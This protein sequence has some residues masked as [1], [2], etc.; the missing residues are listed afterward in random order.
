[1]T[2][3]DELTVAGFADEWVRFD[4]TQL[5]PEE[6]QMMFDEYFSVFPWDILS[7]GAVGADI[8]CRS[9]RWAT[10]VAPR[11]GTLHAVDPSN[12]IE[13]A[14]RVCASHPNVRFHQVGVDD[15]PFG[16]ASLDFAYAFGVLHHV[17]DTAS[18]IAAIGSTQRARLGK[19]SRARMERFYS[20]SG[21][22]GAYAELYRGLTDERAFKNSVASA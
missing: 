19:R 8:G 12:A 22:I 20:V 14:R 15:L 18:A 6:R 17:P 16:D 5:T 1:M 13:V 21:M 11:V 4:Q 3:L 10:M 2:N 7:V 9:G